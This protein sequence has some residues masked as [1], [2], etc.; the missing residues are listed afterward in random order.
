M[1]QHQFNQIIVNFM[2]NSSLKEISLSHLNLS[3]A[4]MRRLVKNASGVFRNEKEVETLGHPKKNVENKYFYVIEE[5]G[6]YVLGRMY[7]FFV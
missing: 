2:G 4:E 7:G 5:N 6:S 3:E 1:D